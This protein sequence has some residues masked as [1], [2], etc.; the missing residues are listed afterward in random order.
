[1][2]IILSIR[3]NERDIEMVTYWV[4]LVLADSRREFSVA[5]FDFLLFS[6]RKAGCFEVSDGLAG[7]EVLLP[8]NCS[9][10]V[11][12]HSNCQVDNCD[13]YFVTENTIKRKGVKRSI[14]HLATKQHKQRHCR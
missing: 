5:G 1:M 13:Q 10:V 9:F 2:L 12:G 11:H 14:Y 6:L 4:W 3:P 7:F 8:S